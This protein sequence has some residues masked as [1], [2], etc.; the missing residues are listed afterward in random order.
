[1]KHAPFIHTIVSLALIAFVM[2]AAPA[3]GDNPPEQA[4]AWADD[5]I[6][7]FERL[8]VQDE[9][10]VKPLS[11]YAAFKL[12][13][14]NG[15]RKCA[16]RDDVSASPIKRMI[17][18][19]GASDGEPKGRML[20]PTEWVLD[21]LFY[22]QVTVH[23]E[24]FLIENTEDL[25]AINVSRADKKKRDR[26]SY[27]ELA[28][29]R[30]RLMELGQ[31]YAAIPQKERTY[32]QAQLANLATNVMEFEGLIHYFDFARHAYPVDS[33]SIPGD[34]EN[35]FS[36][37]LANAHLLRVAL[38][39]L[40]HGADSLDQMMEP[41]EA[42]KFR[43]LLPDA[44]E[45]M[46]PAARKAGL[47]ALKG[48]LNEVDGMGSWASALALL[49]PPEGAGEIAPWLTPGDMVSLA[50]FSEA[51]I[52]SAIAS[53]RLL[54]ELPRSAS[55]PAAFAGSLAQ[56]SSSVT[57]A[58]SRRNEL[59]T[60]GMEVTFYNAKLFY[61]SLVLYLVCF[62]LV[63]VVWMR[64]KSR[65]LYLAALY[66]LM[67][68]TALLAVGITLRCIIRGR[69]PVT[70][71]YET[72]LFTTATAV[73]VSLFMEFVN[74]QRI[75]LSLAAILGAVGMFLAN[76]YEVREGVDTM[77]SMVAVLDTNFWLSTHVTTIIIGYAAGLLAGAM[78]HVYI[79]G[80]LIGFRKE[81]KA[82]Y[83]NVARMTYGVL[84]FGLAFTTIGTV[85]GGIWAAES[86][87]R[88]WGWDPKENGA[89]MIVLWMLAVLHARLGGHI[90]DLG[91]C[92]SAVICGMIVTFS[93]WGIN[94]L[95]VGLHTYGFTSGILRALIVFFSI[96][97]AVLLMG[98]LVW[99]RDRGANPRAKA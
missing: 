87:G 75:A 19:M 13:K 92:I 1:M 28:P 22:P 3:W 93:W 29:G 68:P 57:A 74:R 9:G 44:L 66:G 37:I 71:L 69:P 2:G 95:G 99:L 76:K 45:S 24:V 31:Q 7:T 53:L 96:Q 88:F 8:P 46:D 80:R 58:A 49:P 41:E 17:D 78:G 50:F 52:D 59:G 21:C 98:G 14:F 73:A 77:P 70:T 63:A 40:E 34:I 86:W 47:D 48:L 11:T 94:L 56:F 16:T 12:L 83:R 84:C 81:D 4:P 25:D 67:I 61:R 79:L 18:S 97:G 89:L 35:R 33:G 54:E 26:Y 38:T 90:R 27:A 15:K 23:Y 42:A 20:T 85:F 6:Q 30:D 10:R 72:I 51:P 32:S 43:E 55:D 36:S 65:K 39:V 91:V 5:V 62:L 60:V 64:P 82:F